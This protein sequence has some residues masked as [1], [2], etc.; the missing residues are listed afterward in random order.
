MPRL[1]LKFESAALKEVP[2]G[3][4]PVTIGR[5]PDNDIQIDN[6]AV[7]NYHA[8]VYVEAGS[9]VVEDLNSL[10]GSFLNDIR[11]ERAMLKD[12]DA[13]MIGK[14][15][16]LVDHAHDVAAPLDGLRKAPAPRVNET[17]ILDTHERRKLFEAAAA[18]GE[19]SQVSP[20]RSRVPTLTVLKGRTDQK[21]YR[22]A[23]KLTVIGHSEMATVRLRGWF[24]PEIAAQINKHEDGYYLGRGDR[25][26]KINGIS[27]QGLT[28]LKDGDLIEVGR[29]RL[30]FLYRD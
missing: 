30:N 12:G 9:L 8:R 26:P 22:I 25:V 10:N 6:L 27:I 23:G 1:V 4:S 21:E 13:I 17:M 20:E 15:Q 7:S 16:I 3:T 11:V 19:R 5:A 28:K 2:L 14:H 24:T 29:V 18:A